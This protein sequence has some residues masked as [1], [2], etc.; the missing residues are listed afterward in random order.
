METDTFTLGKRKLEAITAYITPELKESLERWA[1][2]DSRSV[3]SLI[4][5]LLNQAVQNKTEEFK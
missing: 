4:T 2:N 1:A 5:H 3:S